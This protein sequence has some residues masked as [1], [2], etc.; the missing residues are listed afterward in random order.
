MENLNPQEGEVLRSV[1]IFCCREV[2]AS[3]GWVVVAKWWRHTF[4]PSANIITLQVSWE[5]TD[6]YGTQ[7]GAKTWCLG[8]AI[9]NL[10]ERNLMITYGYWYKSVPQET[11]DPVVQ[12]AGDPDRQQFILE[13]AMLDAIKCCHAIKRMRSTVWSWSY[14]LVMWLQ[15]RSWSVTDQLDLKPNCLSPNSKCSSMK[16]RDRDNALDSFIWYGV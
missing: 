7:E 3:S 2:E 13:D 9:K 10:F 15:V 14:Q 16:P 8:N 11:F 5:I 12:V 4:R 6:E 1:S